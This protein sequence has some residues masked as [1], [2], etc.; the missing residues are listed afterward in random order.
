MPSKQALTPGRVE[1]EKLPPLQI[2][3]SDPFDYGVLLQSKMGLKNRLQLFALLS[4]NWELA[5]PSQIC[6]AGRQQFAFRKRERG[7]RG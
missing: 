3:L 7:E 5:F 2:L 6:F 1:T 4:P